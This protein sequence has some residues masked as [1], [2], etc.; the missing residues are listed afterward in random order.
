MN[1]GVG[2]FCVE[3]QL[4]REGLGDAMDKHV[5]SCHAGKQEARGGTKTPVIV[6]SEDTGA[7]VCADS[8]DVSIS[9]SAAHGEGELRAD[10]TKYERCRNFDLL[11][12]HN[13]ESRTDHQMGYKCL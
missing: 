5:Q 1:T 8:G 6:W 10:R 3:R 11:F 9:A 4:R 2:L 12:G 7:P 13:E